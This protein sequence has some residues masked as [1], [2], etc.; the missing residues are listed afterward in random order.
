MAS[1]SVNTGLTR[2]DSYTN[3]NTSRLTA[4]NISTYLKLTMVMFENAS[5]NCN[6]KLLDS[7]ITWTQKVILLVLDSKFVRIS[8]KILE[9]VLLLVISLN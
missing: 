3:L 8:N 9:Y 5:R 7:Q 1:D 2:A 6:S 4:E